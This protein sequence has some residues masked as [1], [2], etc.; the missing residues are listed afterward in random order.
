MLNFYFKVKKKKVHKS[1][2][3]ILSWDTL[4]NNY[5]CVLQWTL[6]LKNSMLNFL[7]IHFKRTLTMNS[8]S[9]VKNPSTFVASLIS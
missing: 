6:F 7:E 2:K 3:Q 1:S 9:T 4:A 5:K 8:K